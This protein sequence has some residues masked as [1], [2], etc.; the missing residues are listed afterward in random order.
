V[1]TLANYLRQAGATVLTLRSG[2][3]FADFLQSKV[4]TGVVKPDLVVL[5]PGPGSPDD[6]NLKG[7]ISSVLERKLPLFGVCLGLQA[8]V[9]QHT[10]LV[11]ILSSK[12]VTEANRYC[13]STTAADCRF[14]TLPCTGS[15]R[16]SRGVKRRRERA[17]RAGT[18]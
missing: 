14:W 15:R 2:R 6:F 13:R 12:V 4:D 11:S 1:H 18:C 3:P 17:P 8:L 10:V 16:S 5:S 7:T 9:V